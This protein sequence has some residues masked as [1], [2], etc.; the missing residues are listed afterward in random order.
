METRNAGTAPGTT[1]AYD[2][3]ERHLEARGVPCSRERFRVPSPPRLSAPAGFL[4]FAASA[5]L[6]LAGHAAAAFLLSAAGGILLL[7]DACGF[8]PLD[9]LGP[10]EPRSVLVVP[11]TPSDGG[12]R[13]VVFSVPVRCRA[14]GR[15]RFPR[16]EA[17]RGAV[18]A[19]GLL[20]GFGLWA[21]CGGVLLLYL[22]PPGAAAGAAGAAMAA[23]AALERFPPASGERP[24]NLAAG[25]VD[26]LAAPTREGVRP[27]VLVNSGDE[28]EV[29]YFLA[30][31]RGPVFRGAVIFVEFAPGAAGP[32]AM[33]AREGPFLPYRVDAELAR[34]ARDAAKAARIPGPGAR[35]LWQRSPALVAMSRGFRAITLFRE[36]GPPKAGWGGSDEAALAWVR[37]VAETETDRTI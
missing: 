31:H 18:R 8:S 3:V 36:E 19:A 14:A 11:G 4:A 27:F 37:A 26:R 12:R 32:P 10:K 22:A 16:A 20:L 23:L 30:R 34:R 17:V 28:A 15:G 29:K 2:A 9:W 21:V 25:W 33:S 6:L 35:T 24:P 5:F 7:L 13:A 1:E